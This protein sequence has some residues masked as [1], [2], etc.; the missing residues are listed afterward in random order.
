MHGASPFGPGAENNAAH[1]DSGFAPDPH[2]ASS[3]DSVFRAHLASSVEEIVRGATAAG[4]VASGANTLG[5][6]IRSARALAPDVVA[7]Y[8]TMIEAVLADDPDALHRL[9]EEIHERLGR[10]PQPFLQSWGA[11]DDLTRNRYAGFIDTDPAMYLG[12]AAPDDA[13]FNHVVEIAGQAF[14]LLDR[15]A[16]EI[17]GE[18]RALLRQIILV[19]GGS[20]SKVIFDGATCFYCWGG[21]F[22]NAQEHRTII[23]M[24]DGLAH[25]SAH[26]LLYGHSHGGPFVDNPPTELHASPLRVD[27]RPLDGIY[28]ATFVSA[29]MVYAHDRLLASGLLDAAQAQEARA[30]RDAAITAFQSGEA[31]LEAYARMNPLGRSLMAGARSFMLSRAG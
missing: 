5:Q 8:F 29:R 25:E 3:A 6:Q 1:L 19:C 14:D 9:L 2:R 23:A 10:A 20:E 11:V 12:F 18:I 24:V 27:P 31:T 16:P 30:M 26:A 15:A 21:L 13:L 17:S 7:L 22:L 4:I 28:H